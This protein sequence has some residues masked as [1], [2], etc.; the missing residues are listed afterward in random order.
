VNG[1]EG[2]GT[3]P[4]V[5]PTFHS[6]GI[7]WKPNGGAADNGADVRYRRRGECDW[8]SGEALWFD[9]NAHDGA[10][11]HDDEYRGSLVDLLPGTK[12]EV[13]LTL[14]SGGTFSF[15]AETWRE[16]FPIGKTVT[17]EGGS[18]ETLVIDEGGSETGYVLYVAGSG[19]HAIDVQKAA[20]VGVEVDASYVILRGVTVKGGTEHGIRLGA[21]NHVVIE[22]CDISDWGSAVTSGDAHYIG[23]GENSQ[24]GIYSSA[25]ELSHVV[26]QRND[27]HHPTYDTNSWDEFDPTEGT[28]SFVHPRGPQGI[29]FGDSAGHH[30]IR[31]NHIHSDDEH[32]FNDGM[33]AWENFSYAGFPGR[34]SDIY[35]NVVENVWDDA[36]EAEGSGMNVRMFGNYVHHTFVAFGM[37]TQSLGPFY[38]YRNV[39]GFSQRGTE[40]SGTHTRGGSLV[41]L[42]SEPGDLE[43]ARG[44]IVIYHNTI[45]QPP[46]PFGSNLAGVEGGID[47]SSNTKVQENIRS[48]NNLLAMR[49]DNDCAVSDPNE[50][51]TNDFDYDLTNGEF[52]VAASQEANAVS[53]SP[54]YAASNSENVFFLDPASPGF[55]QATP[56]PGFGGS[57]IGAF[58]TGAPALAFGVDANW[59]DWAE[60][61]LSQP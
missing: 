42:G 12:Y 8:R 28:D 48:R 37:A 21:V 61:R 19:G 39:S 30:V 22:D 3:P 35:G 57:D 47:Y 31:Y 15:P 34:D 32:K 45:W 52:C 23:F 18:S 11:E 49:D 43:T 4:T 25:E 51:A 44:R 59:T 13:R 24:S 9:P 53:G 14:A 56:L 36:I 10:S 16:E 27:I 40:E 20:E 60:W 7:Y 2:E 29:T 41:K 1:F 58:E 38:L 5:E 26:V 6:L 46:S 17:L 50:N 54:V 33:G 55:D